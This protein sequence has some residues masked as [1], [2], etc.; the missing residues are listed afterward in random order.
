MPLPL[1]AI[2]LMFA[3]GVAMTPPGFGQN[4]VAPPVVPQDPAPTTQPEITVATVEAALGELEANASIDATVKDLLRPRYKQAIEDLKTAE[5]NRKLENDYQASLQ[6]AAPETEQLRQQLEKLP[7]V[8]NPDPPAAA[9]PT[10]DLQNDLETQKAAVKALNDE[11]ASVNSQLARIEERIT[12]FPQRIPE[13]QKELTSARTRLESAAMAP[14]PASPGR[15][16]DRTGL[17][18]N[19]EL[20]QSELEMLTQEEASQAVRKT[21]LEARRDL[22]VRQIGNGKA[23][24]KVL[25]SEVL[26]RLT[27]EANRAD[28][29]P[30]DLPKGDPQARELA[31]EVRS[32]SDEFKTL[33]STIRTVSAAN[34]LTTGHLDRLKK[35]ESQI[36]LQLDLGG[37]GEVM[38]Q[39][40]FE[41]ESQLV[42]PNRFAQ[43]L[44]KG[45]PEV[46]KIRL[47][48]LE[49]DRKI[50]RQAELEDRF[51]DRQSDAITKLLKTRQELLDNLRTQYRNLTPA[52][53]ELKRDN[54]E[55]LK[56]AGEL[57]SFISNRLFW[58]RTVPPV[59]METLTAVPSDMAT[60]INASNWRELRDQLLNTLGQAPVR[61]GAVLL[62]VLGLLLARP[63]IIAALNETGVRTRRISTDRFLW[64]WQALF[65]TL[66]LALPLPLMF[67]LVAWG[68]NQGRDSSDWLRGLAYGGASSASIT[69]FLAFLVAALRPG[70]LG[71]A[72][73]RWKRTPH[74]KIQIAIFAYG[75]V[76]IPTILLTASTLVGNVTGTADSI[77]RIAFLI[78]QIW[79]ALVMGWLFCSSG[80]ILQ[81]WHDSH[82]D[83]AGSALLNFWFGVLL[84]SPLI[85]AIL[86]GYGYLV[87]ASEMSLGLINT[88]ALIGSG[89][90]AYW[91]LL[92]L[93]F[94]KM[95]RLALAEALQKRMA[96]QQASADPVESG[97]AAPVE[98]ADETDL[99][100]GSIS[101]QTRDLVRILVEVVV[102][103]VVLAYWSGMFPLIPALEQVPFPGG[104]SLLD[105]A[106]TIVIL[107]IGT[108][109]V[110]NLPGFLEL[111]ILR[112]TSIDSGTRY[113]IAR[114]AQYFLA[115]VV[116]FLLFQTLQVDW[117]RLGWI[118]AAL[119]VG[120][121]FGLQEVV[122][123]FVCGLIL[124][125]ERPIR[126]GD[127]VTVENVTGTVTR[128]NMRS[129]TITNWDRQDLVVP[130]KNLITGTILNWTLSASINRIGIPVGVAYG[131]D[132]DKARKILLEVAADCPLI[133]NDP[134]PLATFEE[135]GSSSLT[136]VLRCYVPDLDNRLKT[137]T[138]LH[139]EIDKRFRA[140]GIE[141][142]FPQL[143]LHVRNGAD[144]IAHALVSR[145]TAN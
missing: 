127:V 33:V 20:L 63:W 92:R 46:D 116:L 125:F 48:L 49:V 52:L 62:L 84:A 95:R 81:S 140:A 60:L 82:A 59:S 1:R 39:V 89:V 103:V 100:L 26:R 50:N 5:Q 54:Q 69:F 64:T 74:R 143:D 101:A 138:E 107:V 135:F 109:V 87:A 28:V 86:S 7:L 19:I 102:G 56:N 78:S 8:E 4:P 70:G 76:Y 105:G 128:I 12:L 141:I 75:M 145:S 16:A 121:G 10:A 3:I 23:A 40:L 90:L 24:N 88:L 112:E 126:A 34:E 68:L 134:A 71:E 115:A 110:R 91:M 41:L 14:D 104:L 133:L 106:K 97:E 11:L 73:F 80:G 131:T 45:I 72:H 132:T 120:L 117:S 94:I 44:R 6:S 142:A 17:Q 30:A 119:S 38:S 98:S 118:A 57:R 61:Y 43:N 139:S 130:N 58:L 77:G 137:I 122:A 32:L 113:A 27:A 111:A 96:R 29:V 66:L 2:L 53:T 136:I 124:L 42:N 67:G 65:W 9:K 123:N 85:L 36:Q 144:S 35:E 13:L 93:F 51:S 31:D 79:T 15:E 129:T 18:A 114:I 22:L 25:E 83:H 21:W 108:I 55:L 47:A 99:Q 37:T